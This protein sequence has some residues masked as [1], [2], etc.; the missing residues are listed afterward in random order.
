MTIPWAHKGLLTCIVLAAVIWVYDQGSAALS[1]RCHGPVTT[2]ASCA[3][4]A[5]SFTDRTMLAA[6]VVGVIAWVYFKVTA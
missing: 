2:A 1:A 3:W 5:Q 4:H 6:L